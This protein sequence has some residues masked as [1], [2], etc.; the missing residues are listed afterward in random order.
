[1]YTNVNA[2]VVNKSDEAM[3]DVEN[4]NDVVVTGHHTTARMRSCWEAHDGTGRRTC[5]CPVLSVPR[6]LVLLSRAI[7]SARCAN[8]NYEPSFIDTALVLPDPRLFTFAEW[9][10]SDMSLPLATRW[11]WHR[12]T[13]ATPFVDVDVAELALLK[14]FRISSHVTRR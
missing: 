14:R 12:V 1:M 10:L 5:R 6:R 2:L 7:M 8:H 9:T 11:A 4:G 13:R 3:N